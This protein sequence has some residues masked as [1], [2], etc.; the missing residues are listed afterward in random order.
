MDLNQLRYLRAVARE[1]SIT[2]AA[3]SLRVSQSTLS[4]AVRRIEEELGTPLFLRQRDG[5]R[6][7]EAGALMIDRAGSALAILELAADEVRELD[8]G[9]RGRFC[10]GCHDSLG[11][12]FLPE[13]LSAFLPLYPLIDLQIHNAS[14]SDVRQALLAREVHFGL[15]VNTQP[16]PDL[17][18]TT[19]FHDEIRILG[20]PGGDG[21]AR[22]KAGPLIYPARPP[23]QEILRRLAAAGLAPERTLA[24]GDLGLARSLA[25]AGLGPVVL[26]RRVAEDVQPGRLGVLDAELP[27]FH[28]TIHLV[29]RADLPRTKAAQRVREAM[30]AQGR[31][32]DERH[33]YAR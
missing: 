25:L 27:F 26:P 3:V 20:V 11:G 18:I 31:A 30:Q 19:A 28:D 22:V 29:W 8:E 13:F 24:V 10:I 7:T 2:A 16:H 14:S 6:P 33:G 1:G 32:L 21:I 15:V 9:E 23:F 12:Y 17:V 4:E 5:V